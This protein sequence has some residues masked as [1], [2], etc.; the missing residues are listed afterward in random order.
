MMCP[1]DLVFDDVNQ[2]CEWVQFQARMASLRAAENVLYIKNETKSTSFDEESTSTKPCNCT[3]N[4]T[5]KKNDDDAN[6]PDLKTLVNEKKPK[7]STPLLSASK[8]KNKF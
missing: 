2:R 3:A 8:G 7:E 4:Q 5:I 1:L 6:K